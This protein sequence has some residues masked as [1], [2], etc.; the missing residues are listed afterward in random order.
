[1]SSSPMRYVASLRS[2]ITVALAVLAPMTW[3]TVGGAGGASDKLATGDA[4]AALRV[5]TLAAP[6]NSS[7]NG[8]APC[9]AD[10]VPDGD[11]CVHLPDE[12]EGAEDPSAVMT[13]TSSHQDKAGRW[14][15][16]E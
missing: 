11:V 16:Y 2:P 15:L 9:P 6:R 5:T 1:M 4:R 10:S 12:D 3:A 7:T 14:S 13:Q 8:P